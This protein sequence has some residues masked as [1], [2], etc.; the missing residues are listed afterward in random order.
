MSTEIP[1]SFKV[2][3]R[4]L[5][6]E[7]DWYEH[8]Q[9][10]II[11]VTHIKTSTKFFV[12]IDQPLE[13]TSDT[14]FRVPI[15]PASLY[16]HLYKHLVCPKTAIPYVLFH[17]PDRSILGSL[18]ILLQINSPM[19][20]AMS[21]MHHIVIRRDTRNVFDS[22]Q[23]SLD[24]NC[25]R[26]ENEFKKIGQEL[27]RIGQELKRIGQGLDAAR[28]HIEAAERHIESAKQ[29]IESVT[30]YIAKAEKILN[31]IKHCSDQPMTCLT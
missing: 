8:A 10:T 7:F 21:C 1:Y 3:I 17:V 18:T 27:K 29:H 19:D 11:K 14:K 20:P 23:E 5:E 12:K 24:Y 28:A 4:N 13:L 30:H 26:L 16:E 25:V 6:Y 22:L 31:K 2:T 9:T 15:T